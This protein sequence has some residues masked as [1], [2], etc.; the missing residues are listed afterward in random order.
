MFAVPAE[1]LDCLLWWPVFSLAAVCSGSYRRKSMSSPSWAML[2]YW[3]D[4]GVRSVAELAVVCLSA[5]GW[6]SSVSVNFKR[7]SSSAISRAAFFP[8][9]PIFG[10]P[11][12]RAM[13]TRVAFSGCVKRPFGSRLTSLYRVS[14]CTRPCKG[15][16]R[17]MLFITTFATSAMSFLMEDSL[18]VGQGMFRFLSCKSWFGFKIGKKPRF[19]MIFGYKELNFRSHFALLEFFGHVG[20]R[21][22]LSA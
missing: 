19:F 21:R 11:R 6:S 15:G 3:R 17:L 1:R 14:N 22:A 5:N 18:T 20:V 16:K 13:S 9:P 8:F 7:A 2:G 12:T 4:L 10:L